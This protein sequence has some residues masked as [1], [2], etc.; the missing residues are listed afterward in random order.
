MLNTVH[1]EGIVVYSYVYRNDLFV[2]LACYRDPGLPKKR[3]LDN[4][5]E[6]PDYINARFTGGVEK[7]LAFPENMRLRVEGLLQSREYNETL[8]DFMNKAQKNPLTANVSV[9]VVGGKPS[10][11]VCGRG[12][13]EI[14]VENH[15]VVAEEDNNRSESKKKTSRKPSLSP[16]AG[17]KP[18]SFE[19]GKPVQAVSVAKVTKGKNTNK[20][21]EQKSQVNSEQTDAKP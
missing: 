10:Q 3:V 16:S 13:V 6:A 7:K 14:L 11:V 12:A 20:K 15:V 5:K 2:R 8:G 4:G 17:K 21:Q 18:V 1:F 19:T 9:E